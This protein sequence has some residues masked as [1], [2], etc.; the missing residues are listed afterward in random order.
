MRIFNVALGIFFLKFSELN[1]QILLK[2]LLN[3]D[4][5]IFANVAEFYKKSGKFSTKLQKNLNKS[6]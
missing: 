4:V 1:L 5:R 3:F 2:F 6:F